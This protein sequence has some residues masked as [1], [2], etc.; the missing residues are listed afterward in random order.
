MKFMS[1]IGKICWLALLA[2]LGFGCGWLQAQTLDVHS[3]ADAIDKHYNG[4]ASLQ[5]S[6]SETYRGGGL[7]RSEAGTMWLKKP[8]RMRWEYDKPAKKLF[9]TD[10]KNAWF[11]VPGERQARHAPVKRLD[12]LRSPLRY[13][14]GHTKLEKEF[15]SL[16]L[17]GGEHLDRP[18]NF[19]LSGVPKGMGDQISK[20]IIEV[21]SDSHISRISIYSVDGSVTDFRFEGERD[22]VPISNERFHFQPPPGVEVL[23][24]TELGP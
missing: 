23:G 5:T 3:V 1:R 20:V 6:F 2:C 11:Y 14:L 15:A 22:N 21:T 17:A 4:L 16:S 24:A 13:L 7:A 10:G 18:G 9:V 12:D 8:G 19:A